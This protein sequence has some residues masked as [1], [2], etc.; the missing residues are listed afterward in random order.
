MGVPAGVQLEGCGQLC[1]VACQLG[2]QLNRVSPAPSTGQVRLVRAESAAAYR[3]VG[4][5]ISAR[6]S[7]GTVMHVPRY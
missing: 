7:V 5:C 3:H 1:D 6:V 2:P 4:A